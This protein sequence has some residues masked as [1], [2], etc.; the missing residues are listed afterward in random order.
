MKYCSVVPREAVEHFGKDFRKFPVG[1]GPFQFQLWEE[2]VKLVLRKNPFY[3]ETDEQ[4]RRLPYLD[5]VA[6]TFIVYKQLVFMEFIKGSLDFMSGIDGSY[7]DALL[8][9]QGT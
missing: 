7:K 9:K 1:T 4:G 8:T 3:F 6:I 2:G 5:A